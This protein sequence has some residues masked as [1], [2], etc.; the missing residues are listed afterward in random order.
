M[1]VYTHLSA[2]ELT[3]IS[4]SY[5]LGDLLRATPIAEGIENSNYLL[6]YRQGDSLADRAI[7]T[8]YEKRVDPNDVPFY[9]ALMKHLAEKNICVP[10]P[11]SRVDG[12]YSMVLREHKK[13]AMVSFLHGKAL[14]QPGEN[15]LHELGTMLASL[16]S[17]V[18]DFPMTRRNNLALAGW[19]SLFESMASQLDT[20]HAGL[21]RTIETELTYLSRLWPQDLPS[22]IIHADLFPDNVFFEQ[23]HISGV[24]DWYFACHDAYL[25]DLMITLNAWC[26]SSD[27]VLNAACA[28]ALLIRYHQL[29]PISAEELCLLPI[30]ARGA[31][32][33]FLLT[34]AYDWLNRQ[35]GALV[36]VK[37]PLEYL[38]I[39]TVHQSMTHASDY[40]L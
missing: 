30:L 28:K 29:R 16:H 5:G 22:G 25:Y 7:F 12:A 14:T 11:L 8:I 40:G 21:A 3:D 10:R 32:L 2:E 26:F 27:G 18:S 13:A 24:I 20:I 37:D 38:R 35:E 9:L 6:E 39:L 4:H 36:T 15:H 1:A 34:R 31:A 33:R 17:A 23:D 19:Q